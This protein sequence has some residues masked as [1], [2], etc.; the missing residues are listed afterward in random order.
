MKK[1]KNMAK[2]I[3]IFCLSLAMLF[4]VSMPICYAQGESTEKTNYYEMKVDDKG[5]NCL[6]IY[7]KVNWNIISQNNIAS[8]F[9]FNANLEDLKDFPYS[10]KVTSMRFENC[11]IESLKG[12]E[13][14]PMLENLE[15]FE[16]K[17]EDISSIKSLEKLTSLSLSYMD[18]TNLNDLNIV[19]NPQ[20]MKSY[21]FTKCNFKD[22]TVIPYSPILNQI[23]FFKCNM[24]KIDGIER[25]KSL[26]NLYF[27]T[28]GIT[29]ISPI[30]GLEN[31]VDVAFEYTYIT[32]IT[33][34]ENL[35]NL[36][37]VDIDN[38]MQIKNIECVKNMKSLKKLLAYN[39]QMVLTEDILNHLEK[40]QITTNFD[41]NDL[42][43]KEDIIAIFNSL[44]LENM[45]EQ[46]KIQ[47]ITQYVLDNM[48]YDFESA[49]RVE[50]EDVVSSSTY[51]YNA[52][53]YAL[54]GKGCCRNY[55]A[56][57]TALM[58]LAGIEVYECKSDNHIWNLI[59]IND[60]Y[61]WLD[62]TWIDVLNKGKIS[63][64]KD[65]MTQ[66]QLFLKEHPCVAFPVE[67]YIEMTQKDNSIV[68]NT[69]VNNETETAFDTKFVLPISILLVFSLF[70]SPKKSKPSKRD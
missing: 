47:V 25:F 53:Y 36:Q 29:D 65:Y 67:Y 61:Y 13:F 7:G 63:G 3:L 52:Y 55:N 46:E 39:C 19:A 12:I 57:T 37:I 6:Y 35:P 15:L 49:G 28:V 34:L 66:S 23:T 11:K 18:I 5:N 14:Y 62:T 51:N 10:N 9:I 33:P 38:C 40:N 24:E 54:K 43:M 45:S 48:E 1:T 70:V 44:G 56:L 4:G 68:E 31:L 27:S 69:D 30:S 21:F 58:L 20:N 22:L 64:S 60:E 17:A 59:K 50:R 2:V 16:S 32:D 41:R 42:Q 26:K 8:V